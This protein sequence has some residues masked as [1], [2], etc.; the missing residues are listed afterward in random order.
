MF[1]RE[2][3]SNQIIA[4]ALEG[5]VFLKIDC[6]KGEGPDVAKRY[7]IRAYPT[8]YAV[9]GDGEVTDRWIGYEDADRWAATVENAKADVRT[10]AA[11]KEAYAA[12]PTA[13]LAARL[14]NDAAC[15]FEFRTAVDHF[16][17]ARELNP[18]D[19][20]HFTEQILTNMYYGAD[21]GGFTFAEV[22]AE[23]D[24]AFAAPGAT[25]ADKVQLAEMVSRMAG[26]MDAREKAI[27]YI[28]AALEAAEGNTDEDLANSVTGLRIDHALLVEK[29]AD[30]AFEMK[31][32]MQPEGWRDDA[33]RLNAFAWW[34]F[35][36]RI[37]LD[38]AEEMALR[39]IE[40]AEDD[41]QRATILDT[42]AEICAARGD[43][44]EALVRIRKAIELDPEND[45]YKDQ[46]AKFDKKAA[47]DCG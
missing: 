25:V 6:E 23:A 38:E 30:K 14:A 2:A 33:R 17:K 40:L 12:A 1:A 27:P 46:L 3:S 7:G 18:A 47:E 31:I 35:E 10:M 42:A 19:A 37:K 44:T 8:F 13:D 41:A 21:G 39:G 34:C 20:D 43:C 28:T 5:A 11:K 22:A 29:D 32:G 26:S 36:N 4:D 15:D 24:L 45:Y 9:N 16:K